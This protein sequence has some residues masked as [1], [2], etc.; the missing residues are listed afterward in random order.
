MVSVGGYLHKDNTAL[1]TLS[2]VK[3]TSKKD[4]GVWAVRLSGGGLG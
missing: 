1:Q 4:E 3:A 2:F